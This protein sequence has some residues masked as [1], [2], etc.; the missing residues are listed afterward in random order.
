MNCTR[1]NFE[2]VYLWVRHH[3]RVEQVFVALTGNR[4]ASLPPAKVPVGRKEQLEIREALL[5][6]DYLAHNYVSGGSLFL[7]E[8]HRAEK[9]VR[10]VLPSL[11]SFG[12]LAF[13]VLPQR[14]PLRFLVPDVLPLEERHFKTL[15]GV[16]YRE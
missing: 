7:I 12:E 4:V 15:F 16:E 14:K 13:D 9:M 5:P 2:L 1:P 10:G 11:Q 6:V 8:H 3:P